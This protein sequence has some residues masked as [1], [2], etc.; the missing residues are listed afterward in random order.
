MQENIPL[1]EVT[2]DEI[3]RI[4]WY[5]Q[6][7]PDIKNEVMSR[8]ILWE[9]DTSEGCVEYY[10]CE[11]RLYDRI[12]DYFAIKKKKNS[13]ASSE[14]D[15]STEFELSTKMYTTEWSPPEGTITYSYR[16]Y[17]RSGRIEFQ[18]IGRNLFEKFSAYAMKF[19]P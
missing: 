10:C 4:A 19:K 5:R 2:K 6:E 8:M 15:I 7:K 3:K 9:D 18:I 11:K 1:I 13:N 16:W 14:F 12:I 17:T